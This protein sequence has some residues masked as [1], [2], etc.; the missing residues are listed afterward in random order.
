M[1]SKFKTGIILI[2]LCVIIAV[3]PLIFIK[4]SE[5]GGSDDAASKAI[6]SILKVDE[7][8]PWFSPIYEPPGR[9]TESLLFCLQTAIGSGIFGFG[10]GTLIERPKR[11]N[12]HQA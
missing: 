11:K 2:L 5:F 9:E 8:E 3:L 7:Y 6:S 12:K 10:L 1:S 4:N